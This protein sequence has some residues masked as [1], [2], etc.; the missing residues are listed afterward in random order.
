MDDRFDREFYK[1]EWQRV[2]PLGPDGLQPFVRASRR[3]RSPGPHADL[4]RWI[5][6]LDTVARR[7]IAFARSA[8]RGM[9]ERPVPSACAPRAPLPARTLCCSLPPFARV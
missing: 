1:P 3:Q 5:A 8:A 7:V 4:G 6:T 2:L 9:A